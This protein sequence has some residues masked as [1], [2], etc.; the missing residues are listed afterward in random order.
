MKTGFKKKWAA[1]SGKH[2]TAAKPAEPLASPLPPF[3]RQ[4]WPLYLE[5]AMQTVKSLIYYALGALLVGGA[6]GVGVL[7]GYF[8]SII[9]Q[10]PIPTKTAMTRT[11]KRM[12]QSTSLYFAKNV[13]FAHVKSDLLREPATLKNISPWLQKALVATEDEEFFE[14]DGIVPK[15]LIRAVFSD[16]TGLGSQTGGSTLTQQVVKMQFLSSETTFKRKAVEIMYALRLNHYFSKQEILEAY[17]NVATLGRNNKGQN[18]AGVQTAA[19]GLFGKNASDLNLAQAAFIAGLPQSPSIYTP[20]TNTGALKPNLSPGLNRQKTVLFRMYRA[21]TISKAQYTEAKNYNLTADFLPTQAADAE[22]Q[23]YTYVYNMV[24]SE[25]TGILAKQLAKKDGHSASDLSNNSALTAQYQTD[26]KKL[27]A[28]KGY[29]VHSTINQ[30]VYDAMQTVVAANKGALG[31]TYTN[32]TTDSVTG[33]T[34]T[35][36]EPVQS[37]AVLMDNTTGAIV[38]FVGGTTGEVNHIYTKRSPG[39]SIKPILVYGPAVEN[40]L[41]GTQTMLADFANDFGSYSVTDYGG[42]IQN[43]FVSAT[44]ALANSYNIPTVYLY[45]RLRQATDVKSYMIKNGIDTLTKND[46]SQLGLALGGTDYG[47]TVQQAAGAFATFQRGGTHVSPYVIDKIVDPV[48]NVIYQHKTTK[49]AV[50]SEATSYI[51]QQM[52]HQVITNGT[53]ASL[54]YLVN[55]DT[56]HLIGKTG[57]SNDYKD[58]WFLG[59]TPGLTM[60]SWMGYDNAG[61]SQHTMTSNGSLVNQRLWA[62]LMNAAYQLMPNEFALSKTMSR[63]SGVKS[64]DVNAETGQL[65]GSVLY[66]GTTYNVGGNSIASLYNNWT[67]GATEAKFAIGGNASDY[68]LFWE[69]F[70]GA[71]NDYGLQTKDG[72]TPQTAA[73]KAAAASAAA[74]TAAAAAAQATMDTTTDDAAT[75][76]EPATDATT[77]NASASSTSSSAPSETDSGGA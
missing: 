75:S 34:T 71:D 20:Y 61:G 76:D 77:A 51:M 37:G 26:A 69:Y 10:T 42:V 55:F 40:K 52:L 59:S 14:H 45:S 74:A 63:P 18:I 36:T 12:D 28:T 47:M 67:P 7:G 68:A 3:S 23:K 1:F 32:T 35:T 17:L 30:S 54:D 53:A 33:Q 13:Q 58:I 25:A 2:A 56:S 48:G 70:G 57:T 72:E 19:Q 50:F 11:L 16:L 6:L 8:A 62:K 66:N 44:T 21:G 29:S 24:T 39:S 38:S 43:K 73:Q 9:D 31:E 46:Y 60:A 65:A 27:L 64:V 22:T 49:T 5:V 15:S 4:T 41:I